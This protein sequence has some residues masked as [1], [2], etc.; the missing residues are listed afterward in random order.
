MNHT[1]QHTD[2]DV[3]GMHCA[4]CAHRVRTAVLG[5]GGVKDAQVNIVANRL[6]VLWRDEPLTDGRVEAA[7]QKA[8]Y[9][10]SLHGKQADNELL[11]SAAPDGRARRLWIGLVLTALLMVLSMGPMMGLPLPAALCGSVS[12]IALQLV[13]AVIVLSVNGHYFVRGFTALRDRAPTM[14][15]L[16][17]VSATASLVF[18]LWAFG[19]ALAAQ[20]AGDIAALEHWAH[21]LYLDSAAMIVTL[22][23]VG[24]YLE[25]R[26]KAGTG[27]ALQ[28][29]MRLAPTTVTVVREGSE[30]L[31]AAK[32]VRLGETVL[33][34]T[35]ER[36]AFDGTVTAGGGEIDTSAMTGETVPLV[37]RA[38]DKVVSGTLLLQ[39]YLEMRVEA[40]G[41][42]TA[43]SRIIALVD[44]A[45][46]SKAPVARLADRISAVFV[47]GVLAIA[48]AAAS[49]WWWAGSDWEF[50]A[51]I[52]LSVLV[53]ACPCALGLATP[54]AVMV[55][56]GRAAQLGILFKSAEILEA[57]A[58]VDTVIV[59]K[60]GTVTEGRLRVTDVMGEGLPPREVLALAACAEAPSEHP[61]A[62]A[63][64]DEVSRRGIV[65][66]AGTDFTQKPGSV[67]VTDVSGRRIIVGNASILQ[68]CAR[69]V[70]ERFEALQA[71]GAT[72]LA[73]L[74][75]DLAAGFIVLT[76]AVRSESATAVAA[77]RAAGM[78][79][80]MATGDNLAAARRMAQ[81]A[82]IDAVEANL[83]PA[84]KA[85]LVAREKAQG[86]RVLFVGDGINDAPALAAADVGC[87]VGAGTDIALEA[88]D[89]VLASSRLTQAV[90][91][92]EL[93]RAVLGNIRGNL[94]WAFAY[95]V[96]GILLA[97]GV[98]YPLWGIALNPMWA[99]AAMS[100]SS[101][102]V[103][104]NALRL[105]HF[106]SRFG[107]TA[108]R[109]P[110]SDTVNSQG[111]STVQIT[112]HIEGMHCPHCS[113]AVRK[114]LAALE[115][116]ESV[117]VSLN[118][119]CARVVSKAQIDDAVIKNTI[120]ALDFEVVRIEH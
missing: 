19:H 109:E 104:C 18:G 73:V 64:L 16:V 13:L 94:F 98:F 12:G 34:R 120:E 62:R 54:T 76:D 103:V 67:A 90:V 45:T 75:D 4:A 79:V 58:R 41:S 26:A 115:G 66:G 65:S 49:V 71:Q 117:D 31:V 81:T 17:A 29:L 70:R 88:A 95:N 37:S 42:D 91:A 72:V 23:G 82:G 1:S 25:E 38:G 11:A 53:I 10:A 14:D 106:S 118:D 2:Y 50:A 86:H 48:F 21:T 27:A 99:A 84:D 78:R 80:V 113:G 87:A 39:G 96:C 22:V 40:V 47:P 3:V 6:T 108:S 105:R 46:A 92:V 51:G 55:G 89:V 7:L 43:L 5:V 60:T 110:E 114:A 102:C 77:M 56:T 61:L 112:V 111:V 9:G 59:D 35:G 119:K 57:C 100:M 28:A 101:L 52:G 83:T 85:A 116:V 107:G 24:K 15:T 20:A 33:V 69:D 32:E 97:A 30:C 8:G 36:I 68:D 63:V 74:V 44:E 93:A